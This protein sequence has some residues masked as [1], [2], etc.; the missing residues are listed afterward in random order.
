MKSIMNKHGIRPLKRLGQNFLIDENIIRNIIKA[1]E[2][3]DN[4]VVEIG[5]GLGALTRPLAEDARR[6]LAIEL[7]SRLAAILSETMSG[8]TNVEIINQDAL[9]VDYDQLLGERGIDEG[10]VVIGNLPYY[11]ATPIILRLLEG[12]YNVKR[13]IFMLQKE[14]AD[15][16]MAKPGTKDYGALTLAVQYRAGVSLMIKVPPTVFTPRPA[17]DSAVIKLIKH[18]KPPVKVDDPGLM[19]ALIKAGFGKRRKILLNSLTASSLGISKGELIEACNAA[20]IDTQA[21]MEQLS[22]EEIA[23]LA[24]LLQKEGGQN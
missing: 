23:R 12:G 24:N 13:F 14:V 10:V 1:A 18:P 11:I 22:L 2:V 21:R 9:K 15:R 19:F 8:Y 16:M 17:V 3:V 20:D 6:V 4:V 7:D 5:P